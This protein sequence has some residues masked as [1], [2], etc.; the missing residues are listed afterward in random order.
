M[1][2]LEL[3]VP[4]L[5]LVA[6]FA[7]AMLLASRVLPSLSFPLPGRQLL[8]GGLALAGLAVALLGVHAFRKHQ[9]TVNPFTPEASA[10][11]VV[12]GVYRLSRNPMYLGFLLVLA[13]VAAYLSSAAAVVLLP[14]FVLYMNRFQIEPE[15]RALLKQFGSQYSQYMAMVRRWA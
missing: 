10:V 5:M 1:Q 15:E 7:A 6:M 14:A 4:P 13:G 9:T 12:E 3:K 8:T 2:S 11:L